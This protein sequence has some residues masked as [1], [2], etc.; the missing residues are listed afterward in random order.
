MSGRKKNYKDMLK[1]TP[2]PQVSAEVFKVNIDYHGLRE[3]ANSKGIPISQ[4]TDVERDRFIVNSSM[5]Q[6]RAMA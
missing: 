6:I 1:G 5:S 3:Y 4:L 2:Y